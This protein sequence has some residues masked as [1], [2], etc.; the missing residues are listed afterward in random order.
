MHWTIRTPNELTDAERAAWDQALRANTGLDSPYFRPEWVDALDSVGRS[1]EIAI[2]DAESPVYFAFERDGDVA[3]P[4]GRMINDYQGLIGTPA[5]VQAV[6]SNDLLDLCD[7]AKLRSARFDHVLSCQSA[8]ASYHEV[9]ETSPY[10]DLSKGFEAY[11]EALSKSSRQDA[12]AAR[13]KARKLEREVG[14]LRLTYRASDSAALQSLFDWKAAQYTETSVPN[15]FSFE[16]TRELLVAL[17]E[18]DSEQFSGVL[19]TLH[20]G[21]HLVAIHFGMQSGGV[22]HWWFPTYSDAFAAYSPGRVMLQMLIDES[23]ALGLTKIDLGKGMSSY[24]RRTMSAET[25]LAEGVVEPASLRR[26]ARLTAKATK[27]WLKQTPLRQPLSV[28]ANW[29][30]RYFARRAMQ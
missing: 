2:G 19:S 16:W 10:I 20:A 11:N 14:K 29:V 26:W 5:A 4:T 27:A 21:E 1:V 18:K 25:P 28:P 15:I 24:K 30:Y 13:R 8:F 23:S 6:T 17:I 12:S 7:A 9:A 3:F 22:L